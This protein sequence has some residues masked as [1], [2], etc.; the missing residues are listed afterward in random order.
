MEEESRAETSPDAT[1][2]SAAPEEDK[3]ND[4]APIISDPAASPEGEE[5]QPAPEPSGEAEE[6]IQPAPND[7]KAKETE[8]PAPVEEAGVADED[9][10]GEK[11]TEI[12]RD[13]GDKDAVEEPV[14]A[15]NSKS[16][17]VMLLLLEGDKKLLERRVS[18][19]HARILYSTSKLCLLTEP[20]V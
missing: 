5:S 6:E 16:A 2:A 4:D 20:S 17:M 12:E 15:S 18:R 19:E 11:P 13:E 3:G 8:E 9:V 14:R 7:D 1:T 10:P